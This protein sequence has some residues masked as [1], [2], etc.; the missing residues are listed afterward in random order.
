MNSSH[1][2]IET[3]RNRGNEWTIKVPDGA[4]AVE[5]DGCCVPILTLRNAPPD[6]RDEYTRSG[7]RNVV[8]LVTSWRLGA[9]GQR[10]WLAYGI[11]ERGGRFLGVW[12]RLVRLDAGE[13]EV[14]EARWPDPAPPAVG[15]PSRRGGGRYSVHGA[16]LIAVIGAAQ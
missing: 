16:G 3:L 10:G 8:T 15:H 14:S 11:D 12:S 9:P 13:N 2:D 7:T 6:L 1:D 4:S 5:I